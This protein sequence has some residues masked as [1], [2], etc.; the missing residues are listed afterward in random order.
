M[1]KIFKGAVCRLS[2]GL[3]ITSAFLI[4]P[5]LTNASPGWQ[6]GAGQAEKGVT[7]NGKVKAA[8][9]SSITIVDDQNAEQ[10]IAVDNKTKVTKAGK[11]ATAADIKADDMVI[12]VANKGADNKWTAT[13]ITIGS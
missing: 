12:I 9:S 8:T 3:L 4:A 10:T 7:I 6:Q 2:L 13:S 1:H 11:A 5:V